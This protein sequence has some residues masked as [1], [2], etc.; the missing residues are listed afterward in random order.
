MH[1]SPGVIVTNLHLRGGMDDAAYKNFIEHSKTTHAMGR[2]GNV[3]EV[4][5]AIVFLA[6]DASS[7]TTGMSLPV[8]GGRHAMCPR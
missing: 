2:V 6:S 3:D 8:D 7:F 4:A 1:F 5:N